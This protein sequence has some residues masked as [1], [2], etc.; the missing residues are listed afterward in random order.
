MLCDYSV[1][2]DMSYVYEV[3]RPYDTDFCFVFGYV[4]QYVGSKMSF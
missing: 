4:K 3:L 2:F 1:M